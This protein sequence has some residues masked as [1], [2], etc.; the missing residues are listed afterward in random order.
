MSNDIREQMPVKNSLNQEIGT[1]IKSGDEYLKI[2]LSGN[3]KT[4]WVPNSLIER[5]DNHVH[6]TASGDDLAHRWMT[7][8]PE[9]FRDQLVD[10]SSKESFPASDPPSFNP[11]KT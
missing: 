7:K 2:V 6:L 3:E 9:A 4:Y 5:V 10:E 8:D 11:G 1:V